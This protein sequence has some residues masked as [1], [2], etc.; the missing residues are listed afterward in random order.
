MTV[1]R[2]NFHACFTSA[3]V[4][5]LC[6]VLVALRVGQVSGQLLDTEFQPTVTATCKSGH[7]TIRVNLNQ[8]FVGAVHARD[9]R[10]PQCM[11][12]GNGSTHAT[13]A[14]NLLAPKGSPDY[15]GVLVNND[16]EERS[17]PIAVRI[18]K[19]LELADDKFYV[20][21]CGKAGFKNAK[22][23][24]SLVSLRLLDGGHKVQEA[25]YGHNY[26]LRA[27][28]SRP[29]G[30][31]GIKVKS[32]FAF[33]KRNSSV[34]LID[35]KGCPVKA[36]VMTKFIYDRNTGLADATLFS[37]FRFSDST[38]VHFQC[39]IAV[40][41]GSCGIPVCDDDNE[42]DIKGASLINRQSVSGE[43]G[44]LLAGTSVFVLNPGQ[45]PSVQS[46]YE[47]GSVHPVWLLWLAVALG[48]LFLIMLIIN[49]FLC[50]AMTCSCTRT[51]IIE[52]E[53][54]IIEDYDPYRS[55][56]GS[57]Y[58]SRYSLNGKQGY[59]SGGSTMNSTRSISTNSDHYAI[60]HSRPGSR[61]SGPGQKH[62]HHHRGPPSN[63]GSH[64]SG[65]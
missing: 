44:V 62:H 40:C 59:A 58:G 39:D 11:A 5:V 46:L 2:T 7:M 33:N 49:I 32:C 42:E 18:H 41:R 22:N 27:E 28:I 45:T 31:Y 56:H 34:Q 52:K 6:L 38:Q 65:K 16:T 57:Q 54:S 50:S 35:D 8:S 25:I 9:F 60:V 4:S 17:I 64:Y 37:M 14:I 23:E 63:I 30:M 43:E 53:P 55:W 1:G 51:D 26:T 61:Y 15:C 12:P 19:T 36:Q 48:I 10:T 21:T 13:L 3:L 29:D 20:I 47:D 24:T